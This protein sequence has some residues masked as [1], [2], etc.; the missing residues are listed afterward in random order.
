VPSGGEIEET[1]VFSNATTYNMELMVYDAT[2]ADAAS[3]PATIVG[4]GG[5]APVSNLRLQPDSYAKL[6][7]GRDIRFDITG[8]D[9][10]GDSV[11][12]ELEFGDETAPYV[13]S[14]SDTE[15]GFETSTS[16]SFAL[17]TDYTLTLNATDGRNY[18]TVSLVLPIAE[19]GGGGTS[20][21]L[22][23]GI[24]GAVAVIAVVAVYVIRRRGPGKKEEEDIRLP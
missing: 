11:D 23:A 9:I 10:E 14:L 24:V 20:W 1:H 7:A 18:T 6:T 22:I 17:A 12:I 15:A 5:N 4:P 13:A 2:S 19:K 3:A 16:H 21:V 8:K